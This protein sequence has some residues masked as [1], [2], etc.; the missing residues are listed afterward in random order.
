MKTHWRQEHVHPHGR[1]HE[2]MWRTQQHCQ[3][4]FRVGGWQRYFRVQVESARDPIDAVQQIIEQGERML[5]ERDAMVAAHQQQRMTEADHHRYVANLWLKRVGWAR[6]LAKYKKEELVALIR[7]VVKSDEEGLWWAC[8]TTR[9]VLRA[10]PGICRPEEY[11]NRRET[12]EVNNEK[13]LY[14]GQMGKTIDRYSRRWCGILRYIWRTHD[15]EPVYRLTSQQQT[16]WTA[17]QEI[18]EAGEMRCV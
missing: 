13:P 8:R 15:Q 1:D 6:H 2:S 10:A 4:F 12:G 7:P 16:C 9:R 3:Q 14:A 18:S 11:V 5:S 17:F